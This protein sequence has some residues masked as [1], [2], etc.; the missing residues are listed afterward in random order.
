MIKAIKDRVKDKSK[1]PLYYYGIV[2]AVFGPIAWQLGEDTF[3][4][5]L[6]AYVGGLCL[7]LLPSYI[8]DKKNKFR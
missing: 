7:I 6:V 2:L 4:G 8:W 1:P 3:L 5:R